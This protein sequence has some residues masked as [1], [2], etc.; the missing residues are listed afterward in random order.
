[1]VFDVNR[2]RLLRSIIVSRHMHF[3]LSVCDG[4]ISFQI[5]T[6]L[7][8]V[9]S[10]LSSV[11][12]NL[13][14]VIEQLYTLTNERMAFMSISSPGRADVPVLLNFS[15]FYHERLFFLAPR[16]GVNARILGATFPLVGFPVHK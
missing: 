11:P 16:L 1:M 14:L 8:K 13:C 12:H 10:E 4:V 2:V 7:V 9:Q 5:P 3:R 6:N 15:P